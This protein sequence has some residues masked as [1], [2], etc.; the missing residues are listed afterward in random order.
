[1]SSLF[2]Y[3]STYNTSK[4]LIWTIG[5]I[6]FRVSYS[7]I[8]NVP[9]EGG[10]ILASN[11]ASYLDPPLL[12]AGFPRKIRFLAKEELFT[13]YNFLFSW[14]IKTVKAQPIKR[15]SGD[16]GALRASLSIL[17]SEE[18]MVVFPEGTRTRN[19][20]LQECKPGAGML[21]KKAKVPVV[22]AYISGTFE[23]FPRT[24]KFPKLHKVRITYGNP[25]PP[26]EFESF[27]NSKETYET[28]TQK[29][30]DRIK[31]LKDSPENK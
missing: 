2:L 12:G 13:D 21:I 30:M 22:P 3:K 1:M 27:E 9:K 26:E 18:C 8:E 20:N 15:G 11:H 19:G 5:K 14:W 29:L 17:Q 28:I 24:A 25:I 4:F 6:F 23:A 16:I 31:E 7:G 10:V